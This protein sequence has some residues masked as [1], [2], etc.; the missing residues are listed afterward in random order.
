MDKPGDAGRK[1]ARF[2]TV[3]AWILFLA[4]IGLM[5]VCA[6]RM[7]ALNEAYPNRMSQRV[8][9]IGQAVL[10]NIAL[11]VCALAAY[12]LLH[13]LMEKL[14]GIR[15]SASVMGLWAA[16]AL[17]WIFGIRMAQRADAEIVLKA[18]LKFA[19]NDGSPLTNADYFHAYSYQLALCLP[20]ELLA[21]LFP[22]A[23]VNFIAQCLNVALGVAGAGVLAALAQTLA[24]E[25]RAAAA[26]I[27]L[28]ALFLPTLM[29][30][31]YVYNV[32]LMIL[33]CAGAFLCFAEYTE[34]SRIGFGAGYALLMGAA[35]AAK[36]NSVIAAM[37]LAICAVLHAINKKD[38]KILFCGALSFAVG[39]ALSHLIEGSYAARAGIAL[40]Q[41][42]SLL[43]RLA[44]GTQDSPIAAGWYNSYT[45]QF[46]SASVTAESEK[47]Q[48]LAD[49]S[50]RLSW[51]R[52]NPSEAF[53]FYRE[54]LMTQW[55]EPGCDI[56]W[57]GAVSEKT[58]RMNGIANM[59]YRDET[60]LKA[61]LYLYLNVSQAALYVLTLLGGLGAAKERKGAAG[62]MIPVTV[63]GGLLY[64]ALF[65]AKAQY[66]YPYKVYMLPLAARG[67]CRL[68]DYLTKGISARVSIRHNRQIQKQ[69]RK[70]A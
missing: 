61:A 22:H 1:T 49:L 2:C 9:L 19:E 28:Y 50:E 21:R 52:Q 60:A 26:C 58:G 37:A 32:N 59:L 44:M 7:T 23:D 30:N 62:L 38:W 14:G 70:A 31:T 47:A 3:A 65:E 20:L 34:T 53:A 51:M 29:F 63:I 33:L 36:P 12:M 66:A 10:P 39:I 17:V 35:I 6:F 25:R 27:L 15:M 48:A 69:Q 18:A 5:A 42:V 67:L 54:K 24:G 8:T 64:H 11:T 57:M 41:D 13:K 56:L 40:R 55:L 68:E 4:L 46:F 45:E 43:A 16:A